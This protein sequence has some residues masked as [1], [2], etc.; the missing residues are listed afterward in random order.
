MAGTQAPHHPGPDGRG[1]ARGPRTART[2]RCGTAGWAGAIAC[3]IAVAGAGLASCSRPDVVAAP[4]TLGSAFVIVPSGPGAI[5][6][7]LVIQNSGS[8]DRLVAVRTS[9]GGNVAMSGPAGPGQSAIRTVS[10]ISIPGHAM[11][12]L[13]PADIHLVITRSGPIRV[14]TN[15][16]LTLVFARAGTVRVAA[17]VANPQ[18]GNSSYLGP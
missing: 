1:A 16:T 13:D 17:Q 15:I 6:A 7:Y 4:I 5:N 8:T 2:R 14:N 18:T 11:V 3:L 10:A 12:R 9:A